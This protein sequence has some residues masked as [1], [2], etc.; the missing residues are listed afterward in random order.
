[1]FFV[2]YFNDQHFVVPAI[3]VYK[4][5]EVIEKFINYAINPNQKF[6]CFYPENGYEI[7]N[8]IVPN[9]DAPFATE[10]ETAKNFCYWGNIKRYFG[11]Y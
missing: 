3:C 2:V 10:I 4:Y 9:F 6:I 1:M 8:V 11:D 5:D 7:H